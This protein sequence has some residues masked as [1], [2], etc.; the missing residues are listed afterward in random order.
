MRSYS[1]L[2]PCNFPPATF[3]AAQFARDTYRSGRAG[4][5][6]TVSCVAWL[7]WEKRVTVFSPK[8]KNTTYIRSVSLLGA[9]SN[10][11]PSRVADGADAPVVDV[12]VKARVR[13]PRYRFVRIRRHSEGS[14]TRRE[15]HGTSSRGRRD[16]ARLSRATLCG[17]T[18]ERA[19]SPRASPRGQKK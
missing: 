10:A 7:S 9:T 11:T 2:P 1:F 8:N 15:N 18:S 14:L 4:Q 13:Q 6:R 16:G 12:Q 19:P 5:N 17:G 3:R